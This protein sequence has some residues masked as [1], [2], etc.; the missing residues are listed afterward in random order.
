MYN[1]FWFA[2]L[3]T[4]GQALI[5]LLDDNTID[6]QEWLIV[7]IAAVNAIMV[8][9][10]PNLPVGG[11]VDYLKSFTAAMMA[12]LVLMTTL[13]ADGVMSGTDW[14]NVAIA[15]AGALGIYA[16]PNRNALAHA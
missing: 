1:K 3:V 15:V 7:G 9:V 6:G 11:L 10:I 5:P 12:A 2:V 14:I 4:I 8:V 13:F 16:V